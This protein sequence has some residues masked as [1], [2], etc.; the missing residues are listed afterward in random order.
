MRR[1]PVKS[2]V[3][4]EIGWEDEVMEVRF[5]NGGLYR[6]FSVPP[7]V[8]LELLKAASIGGFFNQYVRG[9][10]PCKRL[11]WG[12]PSYAPPG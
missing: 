4:A 10:Y 12:H 3:I 8:C 9:A 1:V 5:K 11:R 2:S 7:E 6:Y